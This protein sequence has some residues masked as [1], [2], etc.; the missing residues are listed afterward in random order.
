MLSKLSCG[1][2]PDVFE[3]SQLFCGGVAIFP[4]IFQD[5]YRI[6]LRKRGRLQR[7]LWVCE[8]KVIL[9]NECVRGHEKYG[10]N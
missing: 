3:Y 9:K 1:T 2:K 7:C 6:I 10:G 5:T 4:L 8:K